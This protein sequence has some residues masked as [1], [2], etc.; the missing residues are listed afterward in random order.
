[1]NRN[2]KKIMALV[3]AVL[4]LASCFSVVSFAAATPCPGGADHYTFVQTEAKAATTCVDGTTEGV[5]CKACG[6]WVTAPQTIPATHIKGDWTIKGTVSNCTNGYYIEKKCT[7]CPY[8]FETKYVAEHTYDITDKIEHP[9]C[10]VV[11][12]AHKRCSVCGDKVTQPIEAKLHSWGNNTEIGWSVAVPGTCTI[13]TIETRKC[14][15]CPVVEERKI[16]SPGHDYQ[17]VDA[18]K[19]PTCQ[20]EGYSVK[21]ACSR[22]GD[23]TV[24]QSI[25]K[26]PHVDADGDTYCDTCDLYITAE[27]PEGCDCPCHL[28]SGIRKILF[29]IAIFFLSIFRV[30]PTCGCGA[31]HYEVRF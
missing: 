20:E 31:V 28:K 27:L 26:K 9:Q 24:G 23:V 13:D 2:F 19:T 8:V 12:T 7:Q 16:A 14:A 21:K 17:I 10:D 29:Q 15:N 6:K 3:L 1:M 11:G 5:W 22:C 30:S 4:T 25:S 18:G